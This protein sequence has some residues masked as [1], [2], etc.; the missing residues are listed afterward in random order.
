MT[1]FANDTFTGANDTNV[2][3]S[4]TSDSG[5]S[6]A[7]SGVAVTA[8]GAPPKIYSN[9]L[10]FATTAGEHDI[11]YSAATPA[12][13]EY[14]VTAKV[15]LGSNSADLT[16]PCLGVAASAVAG[17]SHAYLWHISPQT[18]GFRLRRYDGATPTT[19][20]T[21]S[22]TLTAGVDYVMTIGRA[23]GGALTGKVQRLSDNFWLNSSGTWQSGAAT[24]ASITDT[25]YT[26]AD[27]PGVSVYSTT[28]FSTIDNFS[29][30]EAGSGSQTLTPGLFTN[31]NTF[32][33]P[34]VAPGAITLTPSL[35]TNTNTFYSATVSLAGGSQTLTPG[36][37]TNSN[38]VYVATVARVPGF[39]T[40]VLKNNAGTVLASETGVICNVYNAT[41]GALVVH[42]T[43]LTS[44]AAGIV[45]VTDAAMAAGTTY[46]YEIV[47]T[48]ARRLPV[49]T[50]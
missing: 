12:A 26:T 22:A 36:L 15:T 27:R 25:T 19:L 16:G 31:T 30:D 46:S 33:A 14:E 18:P 10:S 29:A 21:V 39:L 41:T 45:S 20:V 6:W 43:G 4:H 5:H 42:K 8:P 9:K 2:V 23:S 17:S 50:A 11:L 32:Y 28:S 24:A 37:F 47:L 49:A 3:T 40:P 44:D 1:Q 7:Y 35:F 48:G 34:T 38:T 13:P